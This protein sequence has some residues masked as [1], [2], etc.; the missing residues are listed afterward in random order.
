[1]WEKEIDN[2][3]LSIDSSIRCFSYYLRYLYFITVY[4]YH[5]LSDLIRE[6]RDAAR[7]REEVL[8][9]R[10]CSMLQAAGKMDRANY[11]VSTALL[12]VSNA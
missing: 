2:F 9:S 8:L 1:M 5:L 11:L 12:L 7:V 10:V 4:F 6:I 3:M